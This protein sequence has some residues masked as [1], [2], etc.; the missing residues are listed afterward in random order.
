LKHDR[1]GEIPFETHHN[2]RNAHHRAKE[3]LH[4]I[5]FSIFFV[6]PTD[7]V[8]SE[9]CFCLFEEQPSGSPSIVYSSPFAFPYSRRNEL[10]RQQNCFYHSQCISLHFST[11]FYGEMPSLN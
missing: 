8:V 5:V 3:S 9:S 2:K 6:F 10:I 7:L 11:V 4:E 1:I